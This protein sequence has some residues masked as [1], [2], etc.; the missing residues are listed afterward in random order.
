MVYETKDSGK[1]WSPLAFRFGGDNHALWIDPADSR[2]MLLGYDH[3]MGITY[4]AGKTWYH[5]DNLPLAQFYAVDVD[6]A[7]PY[8]VA[9]GTQDNGSHVGPSTIRSGRPIRLEDW[10]TVGGGDGQYNVFD[11]STNRTLYTESQFGVLQRVDLLTGE[12]RSIQNTKKELRWNWC[13]PVLVSHHDSN[14]IYHGSNVLLKSPYRGES[15][16]EISPD[17][18]TNDPKK[19]ASGKGGDGNIQFCTITTISESPLVRGLLWVGTDDGQVWLTRDDGLS[20]KKLNDM[21]AGNPGY[22]VSRL[23]ASS[24]DPATAYVS[25][26]GFRNDDFRPFLYRTTDYGQTWTSVVSNLPL[27]PINVIRENPQNPKLLVC[28]T[29]FGV[30]VSIDGGQ[31]WVQMTA[32]LPTQPVHDLVIHPRENELVAATHGRGIFIADIAPLAE[33]SSQVLAKDVHLF[34]VKPRVKWAAERETHSSSINYSGQSQPIGM[35]VHYLLKK[36]AK[37]VKLQVYRGQ[38]LINEVPA[39]G[40]A[41]LNKV[42]WTMTYRRERSAEEKK[43]FQ[44]RMKRLSEF[45]RLRGNIDPNFEYLPAGEGDYQFV[46]KVDGQDYVAS[47]SLLADSWT[48]K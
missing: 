42:L 41:G 1:N 16:Q 14:V 26:T 45:G 37:S 19:L 24:T 38:L 48:Q 22:W 4:D 13:A 32:G 36:A 9:G 8:N 44:E 30:H 23:E 33:L 40:A 20:W 46:L 34:S 28:G 39:P 21:I 3:G 25:Y 17:L 47:G 11:R 29:E 43:A 18:T 35:T 31:A 7:H 10:T 5:P 15:W 2:H 12:T 6:L 27:G